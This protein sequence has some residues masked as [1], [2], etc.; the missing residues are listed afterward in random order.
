MYYEP[1]VKAVSACSHGLRLG[2]TRHG[3]WIIPTYERA[4]RNLYFCRVSF[5]DLYFPSYFVYQLTIPLAARLKAYLT[6]SVRS[7]YSVRVPLFISYKSCRSNLG[8]SLST[9]KVQNK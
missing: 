4:Q 9:F 8:I 1:I 2:A 7:N 5:V 3:I 6:F